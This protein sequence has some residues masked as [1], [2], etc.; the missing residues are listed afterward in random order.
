MVTSSWL[1]KPRDKL[2]RN[3]TLLTLRDITESPWCCWRQPGKSWEARAIEWTWERYLCAVS[4]FYWQSCLCM[5]GLLD[6]VPFTWSEFHGNS[7][8]NPE[9][10]RIGVRRGSTERARDGAAESS[11]WCFFEPALLSWLDLR[12]ISVIGFCFIRL[13][14]GQ[15]GTPCSAWLVLDA[16]EQGGLNPRSTSWGVRQGSVGGIQN[17]PVPWK[18][19][20]DALEDDLGGLWPWGTLC[21]LVVFTCDTVIIVSQWTAFQSLN[22][23]EMTCTV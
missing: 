12:R 15:S 1:Q 20:R 13:V 9:L 21:W 17:L 22:K 5:W 23:D 10:I 8:L 4:R 3:F 6:T 7:C 18:Y 14:V 16:V 2:A 19:T 11:Y